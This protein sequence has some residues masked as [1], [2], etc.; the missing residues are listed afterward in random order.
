MPLV[1]TTGVAYD[2]VLEHGGYMHVPPPPGVPHPEPGS[3]LNCLSSTEKGMPWE[4]LSKGA[5]VADPKA[6]IKVVY[7][8]AWSNLLYCM[9]PDD[10]GDGIP[11]PD[12]TGMWYTVDVF[13]EYEEKKVRTD[14]AIADINWDQE[15]D[16][17]DLVLI[18]VAFGSKDEGFMKPV[19][20]PNFDSR[21]DLDGDGW[22]TSMD[23]LAVGLDFGKKI[24]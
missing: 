23:V 7:V 12:A 2:H 8:A 11:D 10:N 24:N 19:A 3:V 15:V 14:V 6:F 5:A 1:L 18:G 17:F 22:I 4:N 20:D 21:A 16:I 9:N 13:W